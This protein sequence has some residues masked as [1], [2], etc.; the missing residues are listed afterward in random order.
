MSD[1]HYIDNP[2]PEHLAW[3]PARRDSASSTSH[4]S[5]MIQICAEYLAAGANRHPCAADWDSLSGLLAYGA[6]INVALWQPQVSA[7]S[8]LEME[9]PLLVEGDSSKTSIKYF[10][11]LS[12][13]EAC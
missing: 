10:P 8:S 7:N 12:P 3:E 11:S 4:D 2:H 1:N 6:D 5:N 9:F 13:E